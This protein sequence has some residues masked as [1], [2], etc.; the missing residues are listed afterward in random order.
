MQQL[1]PAR[2]HFAA[3]SPLR[4]AGAARSC[5]VHASSIKS[6]RK[7]A[8]QAG[9]CVPRGVP[10]VLS[11]THGLPCVALSTLRPRCSFKET[12]AIDLLGMGKMTEQALQCRGELIPLTIKRVRAPSRRAKCVARRCALAPASL[13]RPASLPTQTRCW[14]S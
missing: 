1:A 13:L 12:F 3:R 9:G 5:V 11:A 4:R 2:L 6:V 8:L 10:C 14:R 7:D